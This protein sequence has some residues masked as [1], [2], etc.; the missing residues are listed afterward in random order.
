LGRVAGLIDF[1]QVGLPSIYLKQCALLQI[2]P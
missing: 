1:S 2:D